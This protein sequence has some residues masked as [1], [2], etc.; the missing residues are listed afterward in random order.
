MV[1][2]KI[3]NLPLYAFIIISIVLIVYMLSSKKDQ[4]FTYE[5]AL[6]ISGSNRIELQKVLDHY[7]ENEHDSLKLEAAKFLI[8]NMPFYSFKKGSKEFGFAFDSIAKFP[9]TVERK[10]I[11]SR[12]LD[13]INKQTVKVPKKE[14]KDIEVITSEFLIKNIDLAFKAWYRHPPDKRSNFNTFCNNILPYRNSNEPI[15]MGIET[16]KKI[17]EKYDW[18]F[19]SLN[20]NVPLES[21]VDSIVK[22]FQ[23]NNIPSIRTKYPVTLSINEYEKSRIGIC[24]D[25]VNYFIYLF[26]ALGIPS[27]DESVQHWG[28][29]HSS[30]HSWFRLEYGKDIYYQDNVLEKYIYESIPKVFRRTFDTNI[31]EKNKIKLNIDVTSEYKTT[32]DVSLPW[33]INKTDKD[34]IPLACVFDVHQQWFMVD[35]GVIK[36]DSIKFKNLGTNTLYL[37]AFYNEGQKSAAN[38]PFYISPDQS[39]RFY[40][41]DTKQYD[42]VI[43]LRKAGFITHRSKTKQRWLKNLEGGYFQIG[44]TPFAKQSPIVHQIISQK[45]THAQIIPINNKKPFRYAW[46]H[47][48]KKKSHLA[49]M[50][51]HDPDGKKIS[52]SIIESNTDKLYWEDGAFDDDPLSLSGGTNYCIGIKLNKPQ[53]IGYVKYQARNDD[54]HIRIGDTYNLVYWDNK[55]KTLGT[56]TATDTLLTYRNVPKNAVLWLRNLTR[57]KEENIFTIDEKEKQHWFGFIN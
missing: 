40:K 22:K 35:A 18:V 32:V 53:V 30:G 56:Q 34:V 4:L 5:T 54:N 7:G 37:S 19:D 20:A 13:S 14:F 17:M 41:P 2:N 28:N 51:F 8:R 6:E 57:G 11:F 50:E 1:I 49:L 47:S 27:S 48:N 3:K 45:S 33:V 24:Q 43:L 46:F 55:W 26:R 52:G 39:I 31:T 42:S 10:T 12:L 16:R 25:N 29:H 9:M 15:E 23:A 38:Y 44:N 21:I 36:N